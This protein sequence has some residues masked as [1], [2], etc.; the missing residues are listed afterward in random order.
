MK[1]KRRG[2]WEGYAV[3]LALGNG[4]IM[5]GTHCPGYERG[6]GVRASVT[7]QAAP[8]YPPCAPLLTRRLV[9]PH[10][11]LRLHASGYVGRVGGTARQVPCLGQSADLCLQGWCWPKKVLALSPELGFVSGQAG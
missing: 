4:P 5:A 9:R 10:S 11:H 2:R 3:W 1:Y 7:S 6:Y 8:S